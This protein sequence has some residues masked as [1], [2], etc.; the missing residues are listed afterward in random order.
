MPHGLHAGM[1][2]MSRSSSHGGSHAGPRAE[3]RFGQVAG[4]LGEGAGEAWGTRAHGCVRG[5]RVAVAEPG[6]GTVAVYGA[7]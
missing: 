1:P 6:I 5:S 3:R 7:A 2:P 4:S